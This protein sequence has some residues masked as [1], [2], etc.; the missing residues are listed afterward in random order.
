MNMKPIV[1]DQLVYSLT[2]AAE[3]TVPN[4]KGSDTAPL[5]RTDRARK[6]SDSCCYIVVGADYRLVILTNKHTDAFEEAYLSVRNQGTVDVSI[7]AL[8][9]EGTESWKKLSSCVTSHLSK[10]LVLPDADGKPRVRVFV[11]EQ[12]SY[13]TTEVEVRHYPSF[14]DVEKITVK[15]MVCGFISTSKSYVEGAVISSRYLPQNEAFG[16][17]STGIGKNGSVETL[18]YSETLDVSTYGKGYFVLNVGKHRKILLVVRTNLFVEFDTDR[19]I[20]MDLE[21]EDMGYN[22]EQGKL[23][24]RCRNG[25]ILQYVKTPLSWREAV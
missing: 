8:C 1:F 7:Y 9:V 12:S 11:H 15:G 20:P 17:I 14:R 4:F 13:S 25:G 3:T 22:A 5:D 16:L 24:I 19:D 18:E 21:V 10:V 6:N 23:A 2:T